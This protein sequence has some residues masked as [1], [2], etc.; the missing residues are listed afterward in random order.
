MTEKIEN[1][2]R[3]P[4]PSARK[5]ILTRGEVDRLR[6]WRQRMPVAGAAFSWLG[7]VVSGSACA[8]V[9]TSLVLYSQPS[10]SES[11]PSYT[12]SIISAASPHSLPDPTPLPEDDPPPLADEEPIADPPPDEHPPAEPIVRHDPVP[13]NS[14]P[15]ESPPPTEPLEEP[16]PEPKSLALA[17]VPDPPPP[18]VVE[19]TAQPVAMP[20]VTV[21]G[22]AHSNYWQEVYSSIAEEIRYPM[23]ARMRGTEGNVT[24]ELRIDSEG[25]LLNV[26]ARE[27]STPVFSR[28]VLAA[29]QRA[30][31]FPS[32]PEELGE[33]VHL[34]IP[35][36]FRI[37]AD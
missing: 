13:Q 31:P 33:L 11:M 37:N 26:D 5:I 12:V 4:S 34:E 19:S 2:G 27:S 29:T 24:I 1:P 23:S 7:M 3:E 18:Q 17:S 8:T 36:S 16:E 28:S 6:E 25:L 35:V 9:L 21:V 14:V 20:S 22:E 15:P 32:P 30:A 10:P